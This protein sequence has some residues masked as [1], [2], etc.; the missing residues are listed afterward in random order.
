M[1]VGNTLFLSAIQR[2]RHWTTRYFIVVNGAYA[3]AKVVE[4]AFG[5]W[6]ICAKA[7]PRTYAL[8]ILDYGTQVAFVVLAVVVYS[9]LWMA[10]E[11]LAR[12]PAAGADGGDAES[13]SMEGP[14]PPRRRA[15]LPRGMSS[16]GEWRDTGGAPRWVRFIND[17]TERAEQEA[18][19]KHVELPC[20]GRPW[21]VFTLVCLVLTCVV[22]WAMMAA[23]LALDAGWFGRGDA[24]RADGEG[25]ELG[26]WLQLG[27]G[28]GIAIGQREGTPGDPGAGGD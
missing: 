13:P 20:C 16:F 14:P 21:P 1:V 15:A 23:T 11:G 9:R 12:R 18:S 19:N 7:D 22:V 10:Y 25:A 5:L 28:M 26:G 3:V 17:L 2:Q 4:L 27:P 6:W 24:Q 8:E